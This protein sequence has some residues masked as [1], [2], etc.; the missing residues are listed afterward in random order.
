MITLLNLF[1]MLTRR[2]TITTIAYLGFYLSMYANPTNDSNLINQGRIQYQQAE[3]I[4]YHFPDSSLKLLEMSYEKLLLAGDT[5]NAIQSQMLH[6]NINGNLANYKDAYDKLWKALSLADAASLEKQKIDLY[7][8]I[9]RYYSFYKRREKAIAYFQ[10]SLALAKDL[11]E[12]KEIQASSLVVNHYSFVS[13]YR[14]LNEFSLARTYIDSCFFYFKERESPI[15]EAFLQFELASIQCAE[16]KYEEAI[17]TFR[18]VQPW[19]EEKK[20]SYLVLFYTYMSDAYLGLGQFE[21]S[22]RLYKKALEISNRYHMHI[23]FSPLVHEKLANLYLQKGELAHAYQSLKTVKDLDAK[24][25]DSRSAGNQSLLEIQDAYRME[26]EAQE[27]L[28]R[29]QKLERLEYEEEVWFLERVI[30]ISSILFIVAIGILFFSFLRARYKADK[31]ILK[32]EKELE[33]QKA[34]EVLEIKNKELATSALK[35]IEK[36]ENLSLLK[37]KIHET[38]QGNAD[39]VELKKVIKSISISNNRNWEE[40]ETSFLAVNES[41]YKRLKEKF[42]KLSQ[43]DLKLCALVKLNLSSKEMA[44][45]LGISIESAHTARYRLR[46]K[47]NLTRDENLTE[48]IAQQ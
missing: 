16:K 12:R 13:T 44:K 46:K 4:R 18:K 10:K 33:L 19:F 31:Q 14:E 45:L 38:G 2:I 43:R 26:K 48:F 21:E 1:K 22:E 35:L 20:P 15:N 23:D 39:V 7:I 17:N 47:L 32:K 36:D 37:S 5:L 29:Q 28:I 40:F 11:I 27:E 3:A 42:P 8:E 30:L 24:F 25:F 34:N 6:A 9:G 41:F